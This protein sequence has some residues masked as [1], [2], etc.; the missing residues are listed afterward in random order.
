LLDSGNL[1]AGGEFITTITPA[2][3]VNHYAGYDNTGTFRNDYLFAFDLSVRA[4]SLGA[5][6]V[7]VGGDFLALNGDYT[8]G[9][10][11]VPK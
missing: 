4:L 8:S 3:T 7:Y 5:N 6:A 1:Y 9:F 10:A 2:A 11:S